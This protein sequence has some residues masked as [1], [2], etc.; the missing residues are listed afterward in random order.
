MESQRI[1]RFSELHFANLKRVE[2]GDHV[3]L[4]SRE[5]GLS[6]RQQV[7]IQEPIKKIPPKTIPA[8]YLD[9]NELTVFFGKLLQID[10]WFE[11]NYGPLGHRINLD[12]KYDDEVIGN[13]HFLQSYMGG[14]A[15]GK[16]P[17]LKTDDWTLLF[18]L[19]LDIH[20][21]ENQFFRVEFFTTLVPDFS[22]PVTI[23]KRG[24]SED[25]PKGLLKEE[26]KLDDL[27]A[28]R[29]ILWTI[30]T[31]PYEWEKFSLVMY[32][33]FQLYRDSPSFLQNDKRKHIRKH[34]FISH[35]V[36]G[37]LLMVL[38]LEEN[39]ETR[40]LFPWGPVWLD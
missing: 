14:G 31:R 18:D 28:H 15:N 20:G 13:Y 26:F 40:K 7:V 3:F 6:V 21:Q 32:P 37:Q 39:D 27:A 1:F 25:F 11:L 35:A 33:G 24:R 5:G 19:P 17:H 4:V 38:E 22:A 2:V 16:W 8:V 29:N 12:V 36:G 9:L 30:P 34:E 23:G 10:A